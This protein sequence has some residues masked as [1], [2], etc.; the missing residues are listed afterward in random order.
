MKE[1]IEER[2][3]ELEDAIG[4]LELELRFTGTGASR[5]KNRIERLRETLRIN[6]EILEKIQ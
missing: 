1:L 6:K 3:L 4:D 2:I 5:L